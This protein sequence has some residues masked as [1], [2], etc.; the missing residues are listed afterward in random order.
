MQLKFK[1]YKW[2]VIGQSNNNLAKITYY[3]Y[4]VYRKYFKTFHLSN[5]DC[6]YEISK[7]RFKLYQ[8]RLKRDP[9]WTPQKS[10]YFSPF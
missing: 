9:N 5:T 1:K 7:D 10:L 6:S 4:R 2:V 3:K 8:R